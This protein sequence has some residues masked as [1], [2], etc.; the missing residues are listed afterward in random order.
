MKVLSTQPFLSSNTT[1]KCDF[2]KNVCKSMMCANITLNTIMNTE[3]W[4][5]TRKIN[6]NS[7]YMNQ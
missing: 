4:L 3:F 6:I 1:K 2:S 5:F 7:R